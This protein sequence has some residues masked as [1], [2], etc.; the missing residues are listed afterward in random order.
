MIAILGTRYGSCPE[1]SSE[2]FT[3]REIHRAIEL[4]LPIWVY[5]L[6]EERTPVLTRFVDSGESAAR[7]DQFKKTLRRRFTSALF[8][9]PEDLGMKIAGDLYKKHGV[10]L[11]RAPETVLTARYRESA[12]DLLADWYDYWYAGHWLS[13]EPF[14]TLS[15]IARAYLE[16]SRGQLQGKR[17]LDVACGTGNT[18]VAFTRAGFDVWGTD[19]SREMLL[20]AKSNCESAGIPTDKLVLDP[21]N[22]TA[23][24]TYL[25]RF[26]SNSFDLIVNTANS[27]CHI[28]PLAEYMQ[29]ALKGFLELLRPGGLLLIDTKR[30]IRSDPVNGVPTF[31]EL[32]FDADTKEWIERLD[33]EEVM[34]LP[35]LGDVHFHTRLMYGFDPAF[36]N[37]VRRALI[38]ITIFG[39]QLAPRTLVVPYYPLPAELL[40]EQMITA[41]FRAAIYPALQDLNVNWKYDFV[42]GRKPE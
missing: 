19:G 38:L 28:P 29:A 7:L 35:G 37:R 23:P 1:G 25:Q 2:S 41:G 18:F 15:S 14:K 33:R 5:V 36:S 40:K 16:S 34:T 30:Y 42:V 17:V 27:F 24:E 11:A 32:R 22:W 10:V 26:A 9:S 8:T 20:R 39:S 13:E 3:E 4:G 6:D 12:Y 31:K 21:I